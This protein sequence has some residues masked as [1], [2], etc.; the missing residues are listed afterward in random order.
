MNP[1]LRTAIYL[2]DDRTEIQI[3]LFYRW[4]QWTVL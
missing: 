1:A 4:N 3:A 2:T